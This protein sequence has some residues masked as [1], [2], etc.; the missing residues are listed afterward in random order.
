MNHIPLEFQG[1]PTGNK[2]YQ[3]N[4]AIFQAFPVV[5]TATVSAL[6]ARKPVSR[7]SEETRE[8]LS[9]RGEQQGALED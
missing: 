5:H 1:T 7:G 3:F 4:F 8:R 6:I 9:T 2:F